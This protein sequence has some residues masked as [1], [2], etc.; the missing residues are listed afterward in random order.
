M[1]PRLPPLP[2]DQWDDRT[3]AALV[4]MLPRRL[5]NAQG[6]GNAM[7]TLVRHPDLT[8]AFL[9]FSTYV[10]FGSTLPPRLRELATLRVARRRDCSYEWASHLVLARQ[11]GL[12]EDEIEAAGRGKAADPLDSAVLDAVDELEDHS[13]VSDRTWEA[14]GEHLDE[15]QRMD[16]VFTVGAYAVLAMAFKT[17]GVQPDDDERP[18]PERSGHD[19]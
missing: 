11:A 17:F 13:C 2:D 9:P 18:L 6:A 4:S 8:E 14:L 12:T 1:T 3:R 15:R 16:L 7:A 10:L 19:H 5:R